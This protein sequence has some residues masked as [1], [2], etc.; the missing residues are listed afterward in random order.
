M[1]ALVDAALLPIALLFQSTGMLGDRLPGNIML[2]AQRLEVLAK[3]LEIRAP[4][5]NEP[6]P[7]LH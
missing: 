7:V 5:L 6:P 1:T 2:L 3:G 4:N